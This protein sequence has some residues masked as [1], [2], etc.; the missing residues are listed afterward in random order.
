MTKIPKRFHW[1]FW[2]VNAAA[3]EPATSTN[4][5]IPRILEFGGID[6]VRWAVATYGMDGIHRFLRE[7]GHPEL[8]E[9]TLRFWRAALKAEDET[10]ASSP[11]FRKS[12]AAPWIA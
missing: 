7:V 9:R 1:V 12:S 11:A 5:I 2:D 6:E 10:W 4:Y 8:S 3:L